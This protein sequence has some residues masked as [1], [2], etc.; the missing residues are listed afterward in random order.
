M[1]N[2]DPTGPVLLYFRKA[3]DLINHELLLKKLSMYRVS[4]QFLIWCRSYLTER[5]QDVKY[6]QSL[7]EPQLVMSGMPQ[8]SVI[9][10][11]YK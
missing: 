6:K 9:H 7:S 8:G 1:N 11:I 4:E 3:F 10:N 5:Q 2:D